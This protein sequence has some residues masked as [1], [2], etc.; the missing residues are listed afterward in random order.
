MLYK[1]L[2]NFYNIIHS[3]YHLLWANK[4]TL[5]QVCGDVKF[6]PK[7][8][9]DNHAKAYPFHLGFSNPMRDPQ[10]IWV[11]FCTYEVEETICS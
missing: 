4:K 11:S 7:W 10:N 5:L 9:D 3:C 8:T 2:I 6:T 1:Q